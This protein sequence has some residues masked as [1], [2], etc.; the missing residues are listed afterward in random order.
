MN[1]KLTLNLICLS[2]L[3]T[4]ISAAPAL[5]IQGLEARA[6]PD[7]IVSIT[8]S[9]IYWYVLTIRLVFEPSLMS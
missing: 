1:F 4:F 2:L 8:D 3:P 6:A 5:D 7:N 9:N